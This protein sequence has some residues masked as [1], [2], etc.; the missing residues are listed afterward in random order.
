MSPQR[1]GS[2]RGS[3]WK[4]PRDRHE[5]V[6]AVLASLAIIVATAALIW[7]LRPNRE[8]EA[9]PTVET[10]VTTTTVPGETTT[11]PTTTAPASSTP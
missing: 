3:G 6:V 11:L 1:K 2:R 8:S 9:T 10:V 4:A 7:F 5:I